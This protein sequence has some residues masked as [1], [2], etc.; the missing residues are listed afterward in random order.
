VPEARR[1][2]SACP[3]IAVGAERCLYFDQLGAGAGPATLWIVLRDSRGGVAT[4]A[5]SVIVE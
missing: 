2:R 3:L 1:R 5:V 4:R